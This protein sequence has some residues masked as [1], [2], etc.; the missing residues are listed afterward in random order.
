MNPGE[1]LSQDLDDYT[2]ADR[3]RIEKLIEEAR[4]ETRAMLQPSA[5]AAAVLV[6]GTGAPDGVFTAVNQ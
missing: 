4:G 2:P 5:D 1:P 3:A 6:G